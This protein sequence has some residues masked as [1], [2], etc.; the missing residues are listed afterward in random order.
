MKEELKIKLKILFATPG[1]E[2]AFKELIDYRIENHKD[3]LL[4][5]NTVTELENIKGAIF[6][7][8]KLKDFRKMLEV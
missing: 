7:L 8:R 5:V 4:T 2:E 6:E 1:F 3:F